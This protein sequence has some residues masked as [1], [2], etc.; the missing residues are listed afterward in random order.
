MGS[1]AN[2]KVFTVN[3]ARAVKEMS[4]RDATTLSKW[5]IE[6]KPLRC[7]DE[8][9]RNLVHQPIDRIYFY[10]PAPTTRIITQDNYD[11]TLT[12]D[13][14]VLT[15]DGWMKVADLKVGTV[16]ME[17]GMDHPP[18]Q[19]KTVLTRL[20]VEQ[21]KTQKEIAEMYGVS[22][23]TIRDWVA[24]FDLHRGDAGALFGED[25]PAWKGD[26]VSRLGGYDRTHRISDGNIKLVCERCGGTEDIQIH[27]RDRDPT[28]TDSS[29]L[30][31]LCV[32]CHKAEHLGAP[33]RWIRPAE[34]T[35][36]SYGGSE[37]TYG[38]RT[39]SGNI[40]VDGLIVRF[41]IETANT[42]KEFGAS[43]GKLQ[44]KTSQNDETQ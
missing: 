31:V 1:I 8:S 34:I 42:I 25:N 41:P 20:Y 4:I 7:Y 11:C 21:G 15:M 19:D 12:N 3:K 37:K 40:V 26:D 30:E 2:G 5:S 33:V 6:E 9:A 35:R 43:D 27:H 24:R 29:N 23:R 38:L 22:P 18:Y 44:F 13:T 17:N 14:E 10:A 16:L 32:M 39:P 28:D 36:L